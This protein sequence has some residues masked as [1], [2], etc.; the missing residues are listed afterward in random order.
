MVKRSRPQPWTNA[1]W[2][3]VVRR[4]KELN[5][6]APPKTWSEALSILEIIVGVLERS[7]LTNAARRMRAVGVFLREREKR[8]QLYAGRTTNRTRQGR[9]GRRSRTVNSLLARR[10]P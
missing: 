7:D 5:F 8:K 4:P 2:T 10:T 9:D 3:P 1:R 6:D